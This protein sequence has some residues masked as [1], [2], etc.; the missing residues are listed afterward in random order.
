MLLNTTSKIICMTENQV[1]DILLMY[2]ENQQKKTVRLP[3]IYSLN[4]WLKKEYQEFCMV[5]SINENYRILNGIEEK[6][7][8]EKIIKND[9]KGD[10]FQ[11]NQIDSI[12]EK[13][14]SA[15][16]KIREY[17]IKNIE[18]KDYIFTVEGRKFN[19]WLDQF[20][21][22]CTEK[23]LLSK[24]NFIEFFIEKQI[25]FNIVNDQEL[26]L[27]GFDDKKPLYEEL[28]SVL[29]EKN[30]IKEHR[31]KEEKIKRLQEIQC[32]NVEAEIKEITQWVSQN[33]NKKLLIISPALSKYQTKLVNELDREIQPDIYNDYDKNNIYNSNLQ[34]PLSKE[35]IVIAAINL[36]KL[37]NADQTNTKLF[38]ESLIF[39]NWIDSN[40]YQDREQLANYINSKKIPKIS[41]TLLIKLI[42]ND[43]KVKELNLDLLVKTLSLIKKNQSLW[44]GK[45]EISEWINLTEQYW[46]E[47]KIF[48]VNNLL[49]FEISNIERLLKS[50]NQVKNNQ[51]ID[52]PI[53]F[54]EYWEILFTQLSSW[55]AHIDE[56]DSYI[57]IKGFEE[58]PIKKY[59]AIWLMNMNTNFCPGKTEFNPF[60][61]EKLQKKYHIFD[62]VYTKKIE[63]V[64]INRLKNFSTDITISYSRK[65]GEA[66]LIKSPGYFEDF[67]ELKPLKPSTKTKENED[68]DL[69]LIED[70][71]APEILGSEISVSGG[72]RALE[73]YQICPAWAFYENRLHANSFYEDEQEEIS[74]MARGNIIHE[75]L[76][77]F[78]KRY[79]NS[80]NLVN[81]SEKVLQK[82]ID[83]LIKGVMSTYK[84][85]NPYLTPSQ[86]QLESNYFKNILYQWLS[87]EKTKRPAFRVIESEKKYKINIDRITFNVQIDRIDE[88]QDGSRLLIDY[89]A[90]S[91]ETASKWTKIPIT[92]LQM[93]VYITFTD[94]KNIS[95][96]G[97]A[98][99]HNKNVKLVGLSSYGQDPLDGELK[100]CSLSKKDEE[101][102]QYLI[103]SWHKDIHKL[104]SGYLS[105]NAGVIVKKESDFKYCAV[106]PL[107]RLAERQFLLEQEDE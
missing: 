39:N 69:D 35:P 7:L 30:K 103:N 62:E 17:R 70:H 91:E 32:E 86:I 13:V 25:K 84:S 9:L 81:M 72:F 77:N 27:V 64:R 74:K 5:G 14:I 93:P 98:Y 106:K 68:Y 24:I 19:K 87:F 73:H 16:Q 79:K 52:Y 45:K 53:I 36:L 6:I 20:K 100:D 92:S 26:M 97:I 15:D 33:P 31:C 2:K 104:T 99:I 41:V 61:S 22:H 40:E 82:N 60:I 54:E 57:D 83:S 29:N 51:I 28:I 96:A 105:G 95:A 23:K 102:W 107:L 10:K 58:N 85:S 88:Y 18:L 65:D 8:W 55:P 67:K 38:Y 42:N 90:G 78:W 76:E 89:K 21:N 34:R 63:E 48:K 37:N 101:Q 94:V 43:P 3:N 1:K 47:I 46:N 75:L 11:K 56:V 66:I 59:D 80:T 12:I 4:R 44:R 49:M 50:L 71:K